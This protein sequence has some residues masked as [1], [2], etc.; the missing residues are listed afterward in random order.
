MYSACLQPLAEVPGVL[1][2]GLFP[3]EGDQLPQFMWD[4]GGSQGMG[5]S[6]QK[7]EKS[8]AN[9]GKLLNLVP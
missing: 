6:E 8:G 7:L 5:L 1:N 2:P 3:Q 4:W 9:Q